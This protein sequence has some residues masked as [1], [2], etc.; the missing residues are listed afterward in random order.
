MHS[1]FPM[2]SYDDGEGEVLKMAYRV[3]CAQNIVRHM[4][5]SVAAVGDGPRRDT[6]FLLF[7]PTIT[8]A[9]RARP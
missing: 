3:G 6:S 9:H 4:N 2:L 7:E 1:F 5:D 8:R